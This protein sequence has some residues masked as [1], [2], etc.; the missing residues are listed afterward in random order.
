M[1][2][3]RLMAGALS[4]KLGLYRGEDATMTSYFPRGSLSRSCGMMDL[5]MFPR[6]IDALVC[7]KAVLEAIV[8][9]CRGVDN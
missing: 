3:P 2:F 6:I 9:R 1:F 8:T 7:V 4:I 5:Y